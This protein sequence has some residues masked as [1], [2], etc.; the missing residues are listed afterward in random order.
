MAEHTTVFI[1]DTTPGVG[2]RTFT[3]SG[4][5]TSMDVDSL[6]ANT[7]YITTAEYERPDGVTIQTVQGVTF[8]TL[9]AGTFSITNEQWVN[10]NDGL[11]STVTFNFTST[12]AISSIILQDNG[13]QGSPQ[14]Q[15][16]IS[17]NTG[18]ATLPYY[19]PGTQH[20]M[21]FLMTDIY[22][23]TANI[24]RILTLQ[25]SMAE[26]PFYI[27]A[28]D[29]SSNDNVIQLDVVGSPT[30]L[31][32]EYSFDNSNWDTYTIGDIIELSE[33]NPK[34]YFRND[35]FSNFSTAQNSYYYVIVDD[36]INVGGNIASLKSVD[37][38]DTTSNTSDFNYFFYRNTHLRD[39]SKLY[40]GNYTSLAGYCYR[41]MFNGCTALTAAPELP[42]TT[43]STYSYRSMFEGCTSLTITPAIM[44][45]SIS[46]AGDYCMTGMFINCTG[47]TTASSDIYINSVPSYGLYAMFQGC[48]S[49]VTAP[50][51]LAIS[52]GIMALSN[53]FRGC[54]SL[55][56]P[57][58]I[59]VTTISNPGYNYD[60]FDHMF[61]D[62]S[63]L[64]T[65]PYIPIT[66]IPVWTMNY[67]FQNCTSLRSADLSH[68][69]STATGQGAFNYLFDGCT[70][71][72]EINLSSHVPSGSSSPYYIG[73][74]WTRNVAASGTFY[75]NGNVNRKITINSPDGVPTGWTL[76]PGFVSINKIVLDP[77]NSSIIFDFELTD[78]ILSTCDVVVNNERYSP[79]ISGNQGEVTID[80][81]SDPFEPIDVI[82][83]ITTT[84]GTTESKHV[85]LYNVNDDNKCD[86]DS[87]CI[88]LISPS[89]DHG[90]PFIQKIYGE[91]N[92]SF[93]YSYDNENWSSGYVSNE[94]GHT[95]FTFNLTPTSPR[96]FL[97]NLSGGDN[98]II[99]PTYI[100]GSYSISGSGLRV[101]GET[102]PRP[103]I[104]RFTDTTL[105]CQN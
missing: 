96:V 56:E 11:T 5:K 27:E 41:S 51:I 18:T 95:T 24:G 66:S 19:S 55:E 101:M 6:T 73:V 12:Y 14:Y 20:S 77:D 65:I 15:C 91:S 58:A 45:S 70:S 102:P 98:T 38:S 3:E 42:A 83:T 36:Y 81:P 33:Q 53:M 82:V 88:E 93:E 99:T 17:G 90:E 105:L 59:R 43:I 54:T 68:I 16:S 10:N 60:P 31:T 62:C 57:P 39:A 40:L 64:K 23:E 9:I 63:S 79:T 80:I 1:T 35:S 94:N 7:E 25:P 48:T 8:R 46:G 30:S 72:S 52:V 13:V 4:K 69:V 28:V 87:I 47:L 2:T 37:M 67:T 44:A 86:I 74:N 97:R 92:L 104:S 71:L 50:D 22:T 103:W 21:A 85:V 89:T 49:L 76:I 29:P 100:I 61:A 84:S 32:L 75:R 26:T 78:E 34:V